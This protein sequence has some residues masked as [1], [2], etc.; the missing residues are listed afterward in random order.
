MKN[1]VHSESSR[2]LLKRLRDTLAEEGD[3]QARLNNIV[4]LIASS[5]KAE[6]CSIYLKK[7][8]D[9]LELFASE[10]L[11]ADSVHLTRLKIGEGLVGKIAETSEPINTFDVQKTKGFRFIPET[12][13]ERYSSFLGVAIQRLGEIL[14]VLIVQN[15]RKRKY[16]RNDLN[17]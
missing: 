4:G 12:G 8:N 3:G 5:M 6:V 2:V 7:D 13:E 9:T 1:S 17:S 15:I 11:K 10:G 14:G 16:R